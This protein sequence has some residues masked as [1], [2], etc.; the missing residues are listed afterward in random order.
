MIQSC[1]HCTDVG[2][3]VDILGDDGYSPSRD[4][5]DTLSVSDAS[6]NAR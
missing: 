6:P 4:E 5:M 3:Q 2:L 1:D